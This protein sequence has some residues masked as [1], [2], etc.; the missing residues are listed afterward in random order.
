MSHRLGGHVVV[1]QLLQHGTDLA[2]CVPGESYLA[3]LD[4]LYDARDRIRLI[5]NR[6]EGGAAIMAAA[7]GKLTGRPGVCLVTRG[8]GATNA[9]IGV[10][11]AH[12]DASPMVLFVG[13]VGTDQAGRRTF[14]EVDYRAMFAPLAKAVLQIDRADRV[15][16]LVARAFHTAVSGE[17]GPVVVAL[18]D[19]VLMHSTDAPVVPAA[20][21]VAAAPAPADLARFLAELDAAARPLLVAGGSG[22]TPE[23]TEAL[24][25]F[26]EARGLPVATAVRHQDLID[27]RSPSYVGTLG[28]NTTP[29]LAERVGQADLVAL[30]GTRP[31]A[32]T[33]ENHSLLSAPHP[34]QR[35]LHVHPSPDVLN[36]VYRAD[37]AIVSGPTAFAT[38][39][40][41]TVGS[42][43]AGVS[44]EAAGSPAAS[45]RSAWTRELRALFTRERP[46]PASG[47]DPAPYLRILQERLPAD[48]IIT[49]GAGAYTA[50]PQRHW[51]FTRYPSQLGTQSGAM[52]YGLPAA[53]AAKLVHPER[54]AVAFAGDGC[55]LMTGQEL[56]TAARYKTDVL[57]IVVNNSSYGTIR[58]HQEARFPGRVSGTDLHNPDFVG[59]ACSFGAHAARTRTPEEFEQALK[60]ARTHPG[61]ALIE[62]VTAEPA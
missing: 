51:S 34:A 13:Q 36:Q 17:P 15:P 58:Q 16:E 48:T 9:S 30:I 59:Y 39:L 12:Q 24:R 28:L 21:P 18:P 50:W 42:A 22:W 49:A 25:R 27:N 44:A 45:G 33:V 32:L 52:G 57:I 29:G 5:T 1:E 20:P 4:G 7:Y 40:A 54:A 37:L 46:A 53:I 10:H 43:R 47:V 31:D 41:D 61:P 38:A 23:G 26:A 56:A 60:E 11:M 6:H 62:I 35:L 8:P 19:D 14:Q 55:L 2:F 3:V